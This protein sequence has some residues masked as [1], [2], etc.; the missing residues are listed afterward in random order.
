MAI[1]MM[2]GTPEC[3]LWGRV[4]RDTIGVL[5]HPTGSSNSFCKFF[6]INRFEDRRWRAIPTAQSGRPS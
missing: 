1:S 6:F 3:S 4:R 2:G 5:C